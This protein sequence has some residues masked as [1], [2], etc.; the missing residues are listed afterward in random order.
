MARSYDLITTPEGTTIRCRACKQVSSDPKD[1]KLLRCPRCGYH[2][3]FPAGMG[4]LLDRERLPE[5][6]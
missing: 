5:E 6:P 1:V 4:G 3:V 2:A